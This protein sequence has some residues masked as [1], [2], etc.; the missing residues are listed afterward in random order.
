MHFR[1]TAGALQFDLGNH[2]TGNVKRKPL[3]VYSTFKRISFV[4]LGKFGNALLQESTS[5]CDDPACQLERQ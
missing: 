3:T 4:I 1:Y 2:S 5:I